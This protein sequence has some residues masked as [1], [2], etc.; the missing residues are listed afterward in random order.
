MH[1]IDIKLKPSKLFLILVI[2][3]LICSVFIIYSLPIKLRFRSILLGLTLTY[4]WFM[5]WDRALLQGAHSILGLKYDANGWQIQERIKQSPAQLCGESTIAS[6]ISILRFK[7]AG[8]RRKRTCLVFKD[9]LGSELYR[10]LL[11]SLRTTEIA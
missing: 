7:L 11:V 8:Q 6:F 10:K 5:I 9:A 1:N 2:I 3:T 4:G